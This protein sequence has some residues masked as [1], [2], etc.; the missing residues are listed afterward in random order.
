M[1]T[2]TD[3]TKRAAGSLM[4]LDRTMTYR[5]HLLHKLS[6]RESQRAYL[7]DAGLPMSEGRC[8]SAIGSF[9]PLSINDL[10]QRA[11]LNKGQ[12]SRAAQALVEKAL[13]RKEASE[14]DGRGVVLR[15]TRKGAQVWERVMQVVARRNEEIFG[16]L[17]AAEREQLSD[18]FDRMIA[19]A[20]ASTDGAVDDDE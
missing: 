20:Q 5:L 6:D 8:L 11:N 10:A 19:H 12:A 1:S 9:A 18:M 4:Q 3:T 2:S 15:L 7:E 17:S 16:C 13:V 14:T